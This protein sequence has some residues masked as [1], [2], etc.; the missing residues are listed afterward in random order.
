MSRA[1][2]REMF[3][4]PNSHQKNAREIEQLFQSRGLVSWVPNSLYLL[5]P[6]AR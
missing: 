2:K 3:I 5:V 1:F 4:E 6:T